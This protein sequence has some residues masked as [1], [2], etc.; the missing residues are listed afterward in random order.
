MA[1]T[2]GFRPPKS[3][4]GVPLPLAGRGGEG[5]GEPRL[6]KFKNPPTLSLPHK[7]GGDAAAGAAL[8]FESP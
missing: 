7:G 5:W 1:A 3:T 4:A 2:I 6:L 8:H